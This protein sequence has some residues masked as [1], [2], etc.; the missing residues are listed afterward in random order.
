MENNDIIP[1]HEDNDFKPIINYED[2][3]TISSNSKNRLD[4]T[5]SDLAKIVILKFGSIKAFG[6]KLGIGRSRACQILQGYEI[7][8]RPDS[9]KKIAEVLDI[10]L[11]VLTQL[12]G[13]VEEKKND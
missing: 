5:L 3:E 11:V 8:K 10:D 1:K 9:I 7:P 2:K 4:L 13:S 12:F 6:Q